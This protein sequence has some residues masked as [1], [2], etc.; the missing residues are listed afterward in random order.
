VLVPNYFVISTVDYFRVSAQTQWQMLCGYVETV[1]FAVWTVD[2]QLY[3]SWNPGFNNTQKS[4]D[5]LLMC[6]IMCCVCSGLYDEI[7]TRSGSATECV[8]V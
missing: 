7:F 8:S 4:V 1:G 5:I 2:L 3:P 6:F